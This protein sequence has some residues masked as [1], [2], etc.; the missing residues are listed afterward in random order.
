MATALRRPVSHED[1]LSLTEHLDELRSRLILCVLVL[2]GCFAFTFW[3]NEAILKIVNDPLQSTQN[4]DGTK[5]S[6]D[7]LEQNARFQIRTG[8]AL[9]AQ[10]RSFAA[11]AGA[12]DA[13]ALAAD[14]T[15][16]RGRY[17]AAAEA[18][19]ASARAARAAAEA[20]P[21]S[22]ERLPVTLGVAE[23]FTTTVSVA[24][25]AA[26]LLALPF[27]LFQA[28]AFILPAFAPGERKIALPLMLMVPFL[29]AAG[30]AFGYFVVLPRAIDFLQNFND[31]DFDILIQARDYYKFAIMF[32]GSIG[33]L[34]QIPIVVIAI[35]R[36]GILTPRQLQR[37]WGY[38]L[39]ALAVL[40]A[41]ATPTPDPL[42]M[43][44][45]MVPLFLL[46]EASILV[47]A[48]LNKVSPPGSLWGED[49]LEEDG[50][51]LDAHAYDED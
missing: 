16:E 33:L 32:V 38:V 9:A 34:F 30:T 37:N 19:R 5:R 24:F 23:P 28:Y 43:L 45:A 40:A 17:T 1:R 36:L 44:L 42:T 2:L 39:L 49:E 6:N 8:A 27:L 14:S 31:D 18:A 26:I 25:Y 51:D 50:L 11:Q 29:F 15:E 47:A 35:T 22:R 20:V 13:L 46:F 41:V 48:W 7:P 3:Q 10:A 12:F 21:T 4:L